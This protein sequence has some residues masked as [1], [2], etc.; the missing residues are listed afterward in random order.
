MV[1]A[2]TGGSLPGFEDHVV[3][4]DARRSADSRRPTL[5]RG[6]FSP[7]PGA[8]ARPDPAASPGRGDRGKRPAGGRGTF[9]RSRGRPCGKGSRRTGRTRPLASSRR[10]RAAPG[11]CAPSG[12]RAGTSVASRRFTALYSRAAD[13][14]A[15]R[16]GPVSPRENRRDCRRGPGGG[17]SRGAGGGSG[18][19]RTG[20][21][22]R[23]VLKRPAGGDRRGEPSGEAAGHRGLAGRHCRRRLREGRD[24]PPWTSATLCD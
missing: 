23:G 24:P 13:E 18:S 11:P 8:T 2:G 15:N 9:R 17:A 7:R 14:I 16:L 12:C 5:R 10:H 6:R 20:A 3:T 1:L 19:H 22:G 21:R 4:R